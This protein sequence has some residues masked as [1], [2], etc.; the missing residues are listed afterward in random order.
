MQLVCRVREELKQEA[1]ESKSIAIDLEEMLLS[2]LG[3]YTQYMHETK[4]ASC[5]MVLALLSAHTSEAE[6]QRKLVTA[7]S[8]A[9]AA[10]AR[11]FWMQQQAHRLYGMYSNSKLDQLHIEKLFSISS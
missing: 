7:N 5:S 4:A 8:R 3:Q 11:S 2:V 9:D 1:A 6:L 10:E